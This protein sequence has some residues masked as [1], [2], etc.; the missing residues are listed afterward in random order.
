MVFQPA[1]SAGYFTRNCPRHRDAGRSEIAIE[2]T[3]WF[4]LGGAALIDRLTHVPRRKAQL[5]TNLDELGLAYILFGFLL[6]KREV[7]RS[8]DDQLDSCARDRALSTRV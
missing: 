7:D 8:S 3:G 1:L 2:K 5:L 6:R 4:R